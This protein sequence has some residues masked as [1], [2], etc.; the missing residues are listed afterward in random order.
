MFKKKHSDLHRT[1]GILGPEKK[2]KMAKVEWKNTR[3]KSI[4]GEPSGNCS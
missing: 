4:Q 1:T 3:R 2:K